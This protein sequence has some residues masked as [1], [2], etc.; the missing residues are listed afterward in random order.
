MNGDELRHFVNHYTAGHF[1]LLYM[2]LEEEAKVL[3]RFGF[4]LSEL[5]VL[6]LPKGE[7]HVIPMSAIKARPNENPQ[8]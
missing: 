7:M 2:Q 6:E 8:L 5:T 4:T 3:V 1:Q